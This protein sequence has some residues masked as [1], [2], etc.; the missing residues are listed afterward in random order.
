L[1][2]TPPLDCQQWV[3][4]SPFFD[5]LFVHGISVEWKYKYM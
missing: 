5:A 3:N 1:I 4:Y 2:D